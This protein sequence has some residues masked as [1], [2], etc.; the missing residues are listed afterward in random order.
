MKKISVIIFLITIVGFACNA[1]V[2]GYMGKRFTIGYTNS[3]CPNLLYI[4]AE[5]P[6]YPVFSH[7]LKLN[8]IISKQREICLSANFS[9][10]KIP[11]EALDANLQVSSYQTE[12]YFEKFS[13]IEYA[14]GLR[15]FNKSK[16]APLG[17]YS[18]WDGVFIAG[19]LNYREYSRSD[20]DYL[21]DVTV[22]T[23]Y[24]GGKVKF[25]GLGVSYSR[26]RQRVFSHK[27]VV[28]FGVKGTLMFVTER[29]PKDSH[30]SSIG[31]RVGAF[32]NINPI[33]NFYIGIGFLPF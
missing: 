25:R 13:S 8:Y 27:Y 28:D 18:K 14:L 15:R 20:Y 32:V 19:W 21:N 10:R 5:V 2:P 12:Y 29:E 3:I 17:A 7:C 11:F 33:T 1:Q 23:T 24:P 30:E 26:G 6:T 31:S 9:N 4:A 16:Y 22:I